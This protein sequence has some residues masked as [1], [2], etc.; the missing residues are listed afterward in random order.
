VTEHSQ[1]VLALKNAW[2]GVIAASEP[3]RDLAPAVAALDETT[4]IAALDLE[5]Y[6]RATL[7]QANAVMAPRGLIERLMEK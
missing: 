1:V 5:T 3:V 4:S 7:A 6:H 2:A